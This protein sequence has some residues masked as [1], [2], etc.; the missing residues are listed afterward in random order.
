MLAEPMTCDDSV[1]AA[2]A[3]ATSW[4]AEISIP[5]AVV[6]VERGSV[7]PSAL[8]DA[9]LGQLFAPAGYP[10]G[11]SDDVL[12]LR[13]RLGKPYVGWKGNV[14]AWAESAGTRSRDVHV[15]NTREGGA[16]I[17][18]AVHSGRLA[19]IGLDAVHVP[20][21]L[22]DGRDAAYLRRFARRFMS[23]AEWDAFEAAGVA[24]D[25]EALAIRVAAHFAFMEA[26]SKALGTGLRLGVGIGHPESLPRAS[27]GAVR[28]ERPTR[29]YVEG[30]AAERMAA[31]GAVRAE[32]Y[33]GTDGEFVLAS[34]LLWRG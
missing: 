15:S 10:H 19:G 26:L 11:A 14:A 2:R 16:D 28:I 32:G 3:R 5:A 17:L 22:R 1:S 13:D 25:R 24:E 29:L 23:S 12:W 33:W 21:L 27:V 30:A 31:L 9:A 34:A 7:T 4:R 18:L 20:R 6:W 8:I